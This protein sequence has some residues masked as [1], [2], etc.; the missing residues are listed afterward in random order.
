MHFTV[1]PSVELGGEIVVAA[2]KSISHRA[3]ML[4]A[5]AEGVSRV[6]NLL[7]GLDVL[8]TLRAFRQLGVTITRTHHAP[9]T[10]GY[11]N[12]YEIVGVGRDGLQPP[13]DALDLANSGTALRLLSGL[14]C[15]QPWA[16]QLGGDASLHQRPMQRIITPLSQMGA[17]ITS[18]HGKPPL[19]LAP[20]PQLHGIIY[21]S[22]I[23]SAQV[24][25]AILL[26]GLYAQ[27]DTT[28]HETTPTR[29]HT[30]RMLAGFGYA[31]T[32]TATTVTLRGGG[33]LQ[34]CEFA[35]PAD[36]SAAAFFIVAALV[37]PNSELT[38]PRVGVN[39]SRDGVIRILQRMGG[40]LRL[41]NH[42]QVG[43]EP[44]ADIVA[45]SSTLH[46]IDLSGEDLALAI[47]EIPIIAIAAACARGTTRITQATELRYK[48]SDRIGTVVAG[49]H[50]LGI[51]VTEQADGMGI[52]GGRLR[53]GRVVS[54]GDHRI[55]MA[56]AIAGAAAEAPV[57]VADCANVAT[58]FP[59]FA[60]LAKQAGVNLVVH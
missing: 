26:A 2:D 23:A 59:Q 54:H 53:G 41:T 25:S 6:T 17:Q 7:E 13:A 35:I 4:A 18:Q 49:L 55:A 12:C 47:D 10:N 22:P 50:A 42:A 48:E 60:S 38:L 32:Q 34:A 39:P 46:G 8:A 20:V 40:D 1:S 44:I 11:A 15:A 21:H 28:I 36:L 51:Q 24:K 31:V 5:I 56:F 45:R 29:D 33:Q 30:E 52:E 16:V 58:S 57:T 14:L 43:G 27:G 37:C 9:A 3:V 19:A